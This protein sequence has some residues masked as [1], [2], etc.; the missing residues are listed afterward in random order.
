[1]DGPFQLNRQR[2]LRHMLGD[3][4][5]CGRVGRARL[6]DDD[7]GFHRRWGR[8]R[9]G[10]VREHFRRLYGSHDA[11]ATYTVQYRING[12]AVWATASSGVSGTSYTVT[13]LIAGLTYQF[14]VFAVNAGGTSAGATAAKAP[15]PAG[16]TF[17][18]WGTGG[19]PTASIAHGSTTTIVAFIANGGSI[20][21]AQ[22]GWSATQVDPPTV[23]QAMTTFNSGLFG[24]FSANTPAA[25]GSYHG[26]MIFSDS[27]GNKLLAVTAA[28]GQTQQSGAA[29]MDPVT[30]A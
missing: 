17:T 21:S 20:A 13:G 7:R 5:V 18:Y 8:H 22:F 19:Y 26:W 10:P 9:I 24:S 25:A 30:V 3:R 2:G 6:N 29:I 28:S 4:R 16:G 15:G 23:L 14:N 1:M 27:G 11:A 12:S